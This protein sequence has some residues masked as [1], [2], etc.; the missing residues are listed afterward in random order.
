MP[1][2]M[3][4]KAVVEEE[5]MEIACFLSNVV[6]DLDSVIEFMHTNERLDHENDRLRSDVTRHLL[7]DIHSNSIK[8]YAEALKHAHAALQR[9][10]AQEVM[11]LKDDKSR[12]DALIKLSV[13]RQKAIHKEEGI[14]RLIK[15]LNQ[16]PTPEGQEK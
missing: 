11:D 7:S 16:K 4:D 1:F 10:H 6:K 15:E 2:Q 3:S 8:D 9:L 14:K 5:L 13:F 12:T